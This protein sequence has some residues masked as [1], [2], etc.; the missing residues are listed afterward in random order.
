MAAPEIRH[1]LAPASIGFPGA[2]RERYSNTY[3][4]AH[5]DPVANTNRQTF[6]CSGCDPCGYADLCAH[7]GTFPDVDA[8]F[9]RLE[10]SPNR[11]LAHSCYAQTYRR[12]M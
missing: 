11:R 2:G 3:A 10:C 1:D 12:R 7:S 4:L 5:S 6:P 9:S 8:G